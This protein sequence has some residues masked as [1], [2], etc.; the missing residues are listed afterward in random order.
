MAYFQTKQQQQTI[1]CG[2]QLPD[3]QRISGE[4]SEGSGQELYSTRNEFPAQQKHHRYE[5]RL[6]EVR[7]ICIDL[8]NKITTSATQR[9]ALRLTQVG[10]RKSGR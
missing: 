10:M 2:I 3:N 8:I 1:K 7:G 9:V 5:L 6:Q 4:Y